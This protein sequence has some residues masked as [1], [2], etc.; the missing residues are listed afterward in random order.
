MRDLSIKKFNKDGKYL[1]IN[2]TS[3]LKEFI[4]E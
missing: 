2:N 3:N 1:N 4:N